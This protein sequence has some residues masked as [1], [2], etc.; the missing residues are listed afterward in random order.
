MAQQAA[1]V[2]RYDPTTAEV[3]GACHRPQRPLRTRTAGTGAAPSHPT[4]AAAAATV[5]EP[6]SQPSIGSRD[7][8]PHGLTGGV[9]G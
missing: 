2:D 4:S 9:T 7:G 6:P 3:P 8:L 1:A 5:D